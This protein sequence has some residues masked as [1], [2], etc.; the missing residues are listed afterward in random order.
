MLRRV[1]L[2]WGCCL[3]GGGT[4]LLALRGNNAGLALI[5]NGI[6]LVLALVFERV[7]YKPTLAAPP[8]PDWQL[9]GERSADARGVVS[10]WFKPAS[11][12]R[13]YVREAGSPPAP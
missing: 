5:A 2:V 3:L 7:R 12:E 10:V 9:T 4:A 1:L 11:G 8:G 13:A 6:I